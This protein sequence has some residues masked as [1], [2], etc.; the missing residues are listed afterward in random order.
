MDS[1][2][3]T[4]SQLVQTTSPENFFYKDNITS[5][6]DLDKCADHHKEILCGFTSKMIDQQSEAIDFSDMSQAGWIWA[7]FGFFAPL[8]FFGIIGNV[9]TIIMFAKFIKKTTTSIFILSLAVVDLLVC[10]ITMPIWLYELFYEDHGSEFACKFDKLIYLLSIPL[11]G[12]ILLVIAI[13]RFILVFMVKGTVITKFRAKMILFF[14]S[15]ACLAIALPQALSF[16]VYSPIEKQLLSQFCEGEI[17]CN[18]LVCHP[19]T[20]IMSIEI[21]YA[22]WEGL[23]IS[24]LIMA[25]IFTTLYSLIFG[26]VYSL[27]RKMKMWNHN[28]PTSA[29]TNVVTSSDATASPP[30]SG[31]EL[32]SEVMI[33]TSNLSSGV[34]TRTVK[35]GRKKRLPHLHTAI[36]LFLITLFFILAYAPLIIMMFTG[37][38]EGDSD[39]K[40]DDVCGR[41]DYRQFI[42][43][44]YFINHV[45][46]PVIYAFMNPRFRDAIR[47][48]CLSLR[49]KKNL[50]QSATKSTSAPSDSTRL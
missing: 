26:K 8:C 45:T 42:W 33:E 13:D 15:L 16:S 49:G 43:H 9:I 7:S 39:N 35:S 27:H 31:T 24:F 3:F 32:S 20:E 23:I 36:T 38:C 5:N 21:W 37:A 1:N 50:H 10:S 6:F 14:L 19:T 4:P 12:A 44:F 46:N 25:I 11:S 18:T 28:K 30:S 34:T 17:R 41:N 47:V 2:S 48:C 29:T 22:L 40:F